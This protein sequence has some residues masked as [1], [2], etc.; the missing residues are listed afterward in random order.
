MIKLRD[1]RELMTRSVSWC[2]RIEVKKTYG[3]LSMKEKVMYFIRERL[4]GDFV[5]DSWQSDDEATTVVKE[6]SL[7]FCC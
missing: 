4:G 2:G 6:A 3:M 5:K 1:S 7:Y